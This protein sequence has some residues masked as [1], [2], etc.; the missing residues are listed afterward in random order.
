MKTVNGVHTGNESLVGAIG[1][2]S[3]EKGGALQVEML[4]E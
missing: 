2:C 1:E 3:L 4:S